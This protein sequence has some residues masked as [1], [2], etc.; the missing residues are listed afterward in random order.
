MLKD[1]LHY[2]ETATDIRFSIV[3]AFILA[4]ALIQ[5]V[6][7][8]LDRRS[9]TAI[10]SGTIACALG[11]CLFVGSRSY[12]QG[13][14]KASRNDSVPPG[15]SR[16]ESPDSGTSPQPTLGSTDGVKAA[17]GLMYSSNKDWQAALAAYNEGR[18][19]AAIL[20]FQKPGLRGDRPQDVY[21]MLGACYSQLGNSAMAAQYYQQVVDIDGS[22]PDDLDLLAVADLNAGRGE[23]GMP[24]AEK[25][26]EIRKVA[27]GPTAQLTLQSES[28]YA[29]C[30]L[31]VKPTPE[32]ERLLGKVYNDE[33]KARGRSTKNAIRYGTS[34]V[35]VLINQAVLHPETFDSAELVAED[36]LLAARSLGDA[37]DM[38]ATA[39][40]MLGGT[41]QM[42]AR[43]LNGDRKRTKLL[44]SIDRFAIARD[45]WSKDSS[46][47]K[48]CALID[49]NMADAYVDL[50]QY[51]EAGPLLDQAETLLRTHV[52]SND[53]CWGNYWLE[54]GKWLARQGRK[55]EAVPYFVN[56]YD[57]WKK[58]H[59]PNLDQAA[60]NC[61]K[62]YREL[63]DEDS[64]KKYENV[65]A[66]N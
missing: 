65:V 16:T 21:K 31:A 60:K 10:L 52:E 47:A 27:L 37:P 3:V 32:V 45:V 34:Y 35:Q 29:L 14:G 38:V 19:G 41:Y 11:M 58:L 64:A 13:L 42:H 9:T 39:A 20:L 17:Q 54:R 2:A 43:N 12:V 33:V 44:A 53:T 30:S 28:N 15:G 48:D 57:L 25:A 8:R 46:K 6:S 59:N 7:R 66:M 18:Y 51:S 1:F 26:F 63:D 23:K 24:Y 50:E 56:A 55:R 22:N 62:L 5:R 49:W 4:M 61:A 40:N 36:L